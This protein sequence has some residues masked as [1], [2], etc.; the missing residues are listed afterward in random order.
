M[1]KEAL[2]EI[3]TARFTA[4]EAAELDDLRAS[5][6]PIRSRSELVRE[7]VAEAL[8]GRQKGSGEPWKQAREGFREADKTAKAGKPTKGR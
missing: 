4:T 7:L 8:A 3:V 6:R 5:K 2:T 1:A